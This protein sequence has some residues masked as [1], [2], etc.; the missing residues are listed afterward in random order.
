VPTAIAS[1]RL[2]LVRVPWTLLS[3]DEDR[4]GL[5]LLYRA[6][7]CLRGEPVISVHETNDVIRVT[8]EV[9]DE[10]SLRK[11]CPLDALTPRPNVRLNSQVGGREIT[12]PRFFL[13]SSGMY[14]KSVQMGPTKQYVNLVPRVIGLAPGQARARWRTG[15]RPVLLWCGFA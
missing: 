1:R 5:D 7:G 13:Q 11:I 4:R 12:G 15:E 8:V 6:G 9:P 3:V 2:P 10:S 14:W